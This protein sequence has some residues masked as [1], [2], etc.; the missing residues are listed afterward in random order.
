MLNVANERKLR[1]SNAN[2]AYLENR[3]YL[4]YVVSYLKY[5]QKCQL[6]MSTVKVVSIHK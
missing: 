2:Q 5:L 1:F 4:N 6:Q 3:K